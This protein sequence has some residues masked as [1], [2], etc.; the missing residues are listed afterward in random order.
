MCSM[1][2]CRFTIDELSCSPEGIKWDMCLKCEE[3]EKRN[4]EFIKIHGKKPVPDPSQ[5]QESCGEDFPIPSNQ[6]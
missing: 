4:L 6:D 3:M 5:T 1:C 2:F